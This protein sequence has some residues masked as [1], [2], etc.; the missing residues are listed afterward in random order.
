MSADFASAPDVENFEL[1]CKIL[2]HA[3]VLS[4]LVEIARADWS[5]RERR[6]RNSTARFRALTCSFE[7]NKNESRWRD[8]LK[9]EQFATPWHF[10]CSSWT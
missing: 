2:K 10:S 4:E 6:A 8:S 7:Q 1:A 9:V 5:R 3:S